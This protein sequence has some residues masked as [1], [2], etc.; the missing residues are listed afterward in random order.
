MCV[1]GAGRRIQHA[2]AL[3]TVHSRRQRTSASR[4]ARG[5]RELSAG[6]HI[7][8]GRVYA[9]RTADGRETWVRCVV[10]RRRQVHLRGTSPSVPLLLQQLGLGVQDGMHAQGIA[11]PPF[12]RRR[13]IRQ[14]TERGQRKLTVVAAIPR[15]VVL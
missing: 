1:D 13:G 9:G 3:R 12:G 8:L 4:A 10:A 2:Q 14:L 5:W 7:S 15:T 6:H 11:R